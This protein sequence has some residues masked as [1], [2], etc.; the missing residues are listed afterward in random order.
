MTRPMNILIIDDEQFLIE[1]LSRYLK[2]RISAKIMC[3][4]SACSA[5]QLVDSEKFDLIIC[6]LNISDQTDG[7]LI[8]KIHEKVPAQRFIIISAQ[9]LPD[10]LLT[11]SDLKIAAYFE[12][13]FNISEFEKA[14]K[15][16]EKVNFSNA[17]L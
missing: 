14:I 6:D 2:N 12:K 7:E 4:D 10:H 5:L 16:I 13:P 15:E 17:E 8:C 9:E 3:A 11:K 1:N